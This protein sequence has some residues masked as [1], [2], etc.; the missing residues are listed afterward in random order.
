MKKTKKYAIGGFQLLIFISL[1][2]CTK[3]KVPKPPLNC[4]SDTI[5]YST[6]IQPLINS[7]CAVSGCHDNTAQSG[8]VFTSYET[9]S[10]NKDLI[11][12]VVRHE[13]GVTPM[14]FN[15]QALNDSLIQQLNCWVQQGGLN[16]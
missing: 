1:C 7:N 4:T 6:Q 15:K 8:Y 14:P 13:A 2:A 5:F 9:V 16:N 12:K 11:M 10:A 3:D